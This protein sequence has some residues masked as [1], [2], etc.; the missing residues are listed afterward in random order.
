M[1]AMGVLDCGW[2]TFAAIRYASGRLRPPPKSRIGTPRLPRRLAATPRS[3]R[4]FWRVL[5]NVFRRRRGRRRCKVQF[6]QPLRNVHRRRGRRRR[7]VQFWQSLQT[8]SGVVVVGG[9]CVLLVLLQA[10]ARVFSGHPRTTA[11][12]RRAGGQGPNL[13]LMVAKRGQSDAAPHGVSPG[14]VP[15]L[16][17]S[18]LQHPHRTMRHS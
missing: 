17:V 14:R 12:C 13:G 11:L 5:A 7:S 9:G 16:A 10:F 2:P 3:P 1:A 8:C 18:G 15:R 4:F 6:W